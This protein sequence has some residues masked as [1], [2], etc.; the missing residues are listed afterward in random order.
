MGSPR[1]RR[2]DKPLCTHDHCLHNP[3]GAF[4]EARQDIFQV[5]N[6]IPRSHNSQSTLTHIMPSLLVLGDPDKAAL[7]LGKA[8]ST[9]ASQ[10]L[11]ANSAHGQPAVAVIESIEHLYQRDR[12]NG[13]RAIK[14]AH[15]S[16][17]ENAPA[18]NQLHGAAHRRES[19]AIILW[20]ARLV[21]AAVCIWNLTAA[22]PFT[23]NPSAYTRAFELENTG[24]PGQVMVRGLGV[25]F[26]MWQVPFLPVIWHPGRFRA[27][28]L[29]VLGMQLVGV[30]G[31]S[32]MLAGLPAGHAPLRA[33][34]QRFI[35][36]DAT[37]LVLMALAYVALRR[38]Q[39]SQRNP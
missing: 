15:K 30:V 5:I 1:V 35:L 19:Y 22:V 16:M 18:P 28:Y 25:A 29:C 17:S 12:L 37:G 32:I 8:A 6:S 20:S 21:V 34:A 9:R 14:S 11:S 27:C 26:L 24:L 13:H 4:T 33:T 2:D 23:L 39:C 7:W 3:L 10:A 38:S 31:E 36:F